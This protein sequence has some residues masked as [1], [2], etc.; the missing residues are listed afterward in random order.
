MIDDRA[1]AHR[2]VQDAFEDLVTAVENTLEVLRWLERR[3][4]PADVELRD[5]LRDVQMPLEDLDVYIA[6]GA[7]LLE[8]LSEQQDIER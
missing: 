2:M 5:D 1:A 4:D 6:P 3:A 8:R 7:P